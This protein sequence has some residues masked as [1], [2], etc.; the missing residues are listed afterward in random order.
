L[1][2]QMAPIDDAETQAHEMNDADDNATR[3]YRAA[4]RVDL[5]R[6]LS[7]TY[8]NASPVDPWTKARRTRQMQARLA[9]LDAEVCR[10]PGHFDTFGDPP[11]GDDHVAAHLAELRGQQATS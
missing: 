6:W 11:N 2:Q 4:R 8:A 9:K 10:T 7:P 5:R 1:E 3:S